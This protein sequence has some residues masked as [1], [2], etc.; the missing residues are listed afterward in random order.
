MDHRSMEDS[1]RG[2]KLL[3]EIW[4][5]INIEVAWRKVLSYVSPVSMVGPLMHL[6]MSQKTC[7][8]FPTKR[9][10]GTVYHLT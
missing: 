10:S 3:S 1:I 5:E 6:Y 4:K 9:P 2:L 8:N 7:I